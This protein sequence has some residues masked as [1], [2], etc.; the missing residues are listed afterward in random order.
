MNEIGLKCNTTTRIVP[1]FIQFDSDHA[2]AILSLL[3][4]RFLEGDQE[5]FSNLR[6]GLIPEDHGPRVPRRWSSAWR[7]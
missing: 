2:D 5:L 3:D 6:N 1:E 4:C 7:N